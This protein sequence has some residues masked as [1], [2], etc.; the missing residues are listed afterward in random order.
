MYSLVNARALWLVGRIVGGW[1]ARGTFCD[2]LFVWLF[3]T[4][5]IAI[6]RD[7]TLCPLVLC[8]NLV[9]VCLGYKHILHSYK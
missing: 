3:L 7:V 6:T 1:A 8:M 9:D 2:C 4:I 5:Q